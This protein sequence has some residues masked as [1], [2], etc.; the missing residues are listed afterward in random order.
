MKENRNSDSPPAIRGRGSVANP[1]GRFERLSVEYDAEA[2][3]DEEGEV[4]Q[5]RTQFLRDDSQSVLSFNDSKDVPFR[6]GLNPYRGCEHGC[7]YCYARP[8][9]EY[10]GLS[11]GLDFETRIFVKERAP[12]LLAAE[13][14]KKS[15]HPEIIGMSGVTDCYQP[16]ERR[17]GLTR[18]CLAVLADFRNPVGILT[19]N[20]LVT[21]DIDLLQELARHDAVSVSISIT[22]LDGELG[23]IMEPRASS[24]TRRLAAI[25]ELSDA[26]IYVRVTMA[27]V[28]PGLT[29]HE[30]PAIF[31]AAAEAGAKYGSLLVLRL[32]GA[33]A[34]LFEQWLEE[35]LPGSKDKV[36]GRI[37]DMRGG[38]L[39]DPRP[40]VRMRG[41]GIF[42]DQIQALGAIAKRKAGFKESNRKKLSAAAFR[43]P[44]TISQLDLFN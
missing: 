28:I 24:P 5:P 6:V 16:V 4:I 29:D 34:P 36:L 44:G 43:V 19:K 42:A 35:R 18:R 22:T 3:V 27:P 23:K 10:L 21:R 8:T 37:R 9:H 40:H 15:W 31:A 20:H 17:L 2:S 11:A 13:L 1:A 30:I 26:G 25:K 33:V 39:N 41:E 14:S 32:P 7:A 38:K 12:E